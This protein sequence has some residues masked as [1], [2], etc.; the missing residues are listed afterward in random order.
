M[1]ADTY[2]SKK[3]AETGSLKAGIDNLNQFLAKG[4]EKGKI[5]IVVRKR[6]AV[7]MA[8]GDEWSTGYVRQWIHR[9]ELR[10]KSRNQDSLRLY[11]IDTGLDYVD[12][13]GLIDVKGSLRP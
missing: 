7:C 13:W 11:N 6:G 8:L 2:L 10:V 1:S 3:D 4:V 5:K 12:V 9:T